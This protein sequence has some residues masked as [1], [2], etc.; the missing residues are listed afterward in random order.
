MAALDEEFT[1]K[2]TGVRTG[3]MDRE[4]LHRVRSRLIGLVAIAG[5]HDA[6]VQIEDAMQLLP[7]RAFDTPIA[8]GQFVRTDPVLK[9]AFVLDRGLLTLRERPDLI[10][11]PIEQA[12]MISNRVGLARSFVDRLALICPW[13]LVAGIS[14]STA[15]GH[16]K[17]AD[18]LD[19]FLVA[20]RRRMWITLLVALLLARIDRRRFGAPTYC[21]NRTLEDYECIKDFNGYQEPLV[22]REAL[23]MLVLRGE[24][25]YASLIEASGWMAQYFPLLYETR[26][27][28]KTPAH[29][30]EHEMVGGVYWGLLNGVAYLIVTSYL[31]LMGL[32]RNARLARQ[33]RHGAQFRTVIRKGFCAYESNK[34]DALRETYRG[35][36]Q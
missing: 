27:N 17:A 23:T 25:R 31:R 12:A 4:G 7:F 16:A 9:A 33:G 11:S 26:R 34:Y 19:F 3:G 32:L 1:L 6:P 28:I 2:E 8:L 18:D 5:Q 10:E 20:G 22:A 36:I 30:A 14:G 29:G 24:R 21:F 35:V 13:L 15:Y